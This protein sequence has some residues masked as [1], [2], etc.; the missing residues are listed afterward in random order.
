MRRILFAGALLATLSTPFFASDTSAEPYTFVNLHGELYDPTT[1][2]VGGWGILTSQ[3]GSEALPKTAS[4]V[5]L[6]SREISAWTIASA[7]QGRLAFDIR[8]STTVP[9]ATPSARLSAFIQSINNRIIDRI[10]IDPGEGPGGPLNEGDTAQVLVQLRLDAAVQAQGRPSGGVHFV[11][12]VRAASGTTNLPIVAEYDTGGLYPPQA[13]EVHEEWD[14]L[15]DVTVGELMSYDA[16]M[17]GWINGTAF[18]P[19]TSGT[20]FIF[21]DPIMRVSNAPGYDLELTSEAGAPTTS[22]PMSNQFDDVMPWHWAYSFIETLADSGITAGCGDAVFCPANAVTRAQMAVFLERGI[23]GANYNPPAASG[24]V[25][26]DIGAGDFAAAWIEQLFADGI[27]A[28]CGNNNYC[29]NAEVT[30]DQMAVFLL[31]AK[32]G[33]GYSPPAPTGVFTDVDLSH[34]A[35]A[36]VEQLAAEGIT[37]GCGDGNYCPENTVTRDQMAVFLVRTFGL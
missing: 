14:F 25:F 24:N 1:E 20:N 16:L 18:D 8:S 33:S 37:A 11:F 34:W 6:I 27:T 10:H 7:D 13:F 3:L 2:S 17:S 26:L 19:G 9:S 22:L 23:N 5:G 29:P 35:C 12:R 31:R 28:G 32:Y 4:E 21:T 36:W 30:R 15:V